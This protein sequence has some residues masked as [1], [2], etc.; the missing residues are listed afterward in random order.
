VEVSRVA[1]E[2]GTGLGASAWEKMTGASVMV[3]TDATPCVDGSRMNEVEPQPEDAPGEAALA[4]GSLR[5]S[6]FS[7]PWD[8]DLD[9]GSS[10]PG[11]FDIM[12]LITVQLVLLRYPRAP[13]LPTSWKLVVGVQS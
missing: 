9:D 11:S 8:A 3:G 7:P 5:G 13:L 10:I 1:H 12:G 2:E 4:P 6:V